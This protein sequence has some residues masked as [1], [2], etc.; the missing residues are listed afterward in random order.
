MGLLI[1]EQDQKLP[2]TNR[3]LRVKTKYSELMVIFRCFVLNTNSFPYLE[4]RGERELNLTK[5]KK[6]RMCSSCLTLPQVVKIPVLIVVDRK[7][8][9]KCK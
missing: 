6:A 7:S 4:K 5:D 9:T 1:M 2:L 3:L 8:H